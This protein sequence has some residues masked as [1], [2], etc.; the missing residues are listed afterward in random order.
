MVQLSATHAAV[1][2]ASAHKR[3][4]APQWAN[5]VERSTSHPSVTLMLQ[6][7]RRAAHAIPHTPAA[8]EAAPPAE[9]HAL[10]QRPQWAVLVS[11]FT[12]QP[13]ESTPSQF[14]K[15]ALHEAIEH[16]PLEHVGVALASAQTRPQAPQLF[17]S[18]LLATSHP[19]AAD[20]SQ[21]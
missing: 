21:S 12:S 16:V 7:P 13:F 3:P 14:A 19:L 18:V 4:H 15:P 17:T 9:L 6:S 10:L 2:L 11:T 1:A 5:E 8:H 20:R